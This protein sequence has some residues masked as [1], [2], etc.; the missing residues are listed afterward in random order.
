MTDRH[1]LGALGGWICFIL[2]GYHG[3]GRH[4]QVVSKQDMEKF[5]QIGFF[6]SIISA[7][8]ALGLLKI[9]IA[10]F[11]LRLKNNN[12]WKWYSRCLWALIGKAASLGCRKVMALTSL[13]RS[14]NFLH[15]RRLAHLLPTLH[16]HVGKLDPTRRVLQSRNVCRL[17][18]HKH[19]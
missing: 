8:G 12:I 17:R 6:G 9:S 4:I 7:I 15:N 16:S 11:L 19:R 18:S 14:G 2:Q 5:G 13:N 3:F 1:Q 10:L